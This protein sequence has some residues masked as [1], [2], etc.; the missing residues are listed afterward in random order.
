[1]NSFVRSVTMDSWSDKQLSMMTN[2]GNRKFTEY[3]QRQKFPSSLD[4][5]EKYD[6]KACELYRQRLKQLVDGKHPPEIPFIGYTR[7]QYTQPPQSSSSA[8]QMHQGGKN[9]YQGFSN[10]GSSHKSMEPQTPS[11]DLWDSFLT[12]ASSIADKSAKT[13][14]DVACK[15]SEAVQSIQKDDSQLRQ[16]SQKSWKAVED[17]SSKGWTVVSNL[18]DA[19]VKS[20]KEF[21]EPQESSREYAS[22][23][24]IYFESPEVLEDTQWSLEQEKKEEDWG[25]I[26]TKEEMK[27][28]KGKGKLGNVIVKSTLKDEG[29]VWADEFEW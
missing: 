17:V 19:A 16:V 14:Q 4:Q 15:T 10:T 29:D 24:Q 2:G 3:L 8:P 1:M 23:Q 25:Y 7:P 21:V 27:E 5:K 28:K 6:T 26:D 9:K 20:T 11:N 12:A 13:L 22:D 18:W